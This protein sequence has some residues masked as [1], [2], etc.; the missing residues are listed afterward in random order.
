MSPP[1]AESPEP[2]LHDPGHTGAVGTDGAPGLANLRPA[3]LALVAAGGA[4]GSLA[5]YAVERVLGT[6]D[7]LPVGTLTVNLVGAF[8]LGGLL[9][10]L[11][12]REPDVGRHRALRLLVGT[13]LLGGFTTYSALA[14][15]A[16]ALLRDG[17]PALA[18]GY[19]LTT[20][21]VGLLA[22]LGGVLSA[23]AARR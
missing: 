22:S 12:T 8:L 16:D 19:V 23:R 10:V 18:L 14:V 2:L 1:D 17:R 4:V 20:V 21:V 7:G 3:F 15:E 5:R 13:G 6:S 11:A 9:E